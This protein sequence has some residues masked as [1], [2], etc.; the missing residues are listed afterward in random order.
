MSA[1]GNNPEIFVFSYLSPLLIIDMTD[2]SNSNLVMF[3]KLCVLCFFAMFLSWHDTYALLF[4]FKT[5]ILLYLGIFIFL[6]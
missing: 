6:L 3:Y 1:L 2:M 4:I 5:F